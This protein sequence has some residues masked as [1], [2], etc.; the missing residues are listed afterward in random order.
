MLLVCSSRN[1][2]VGSLS[3]LAVT[4]NVPHAAVTKMKMMMKKKTSNP[5]LGCPNTVAM[6]SEP[7]ADLN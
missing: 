1:E 6:T 2:I 5:A 3:V 4:T 7:I